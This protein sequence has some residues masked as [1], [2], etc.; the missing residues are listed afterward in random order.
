MAK[1]ITSEQVGRPLYYTINGQA[2]DGTLVE[3]RR[4][5]FRIV[6][7]ADGEQVPC[8]VS[9]KNTAHRIVML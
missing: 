2:Y 5:G 4:D 8:F 7:S 3:V 9:K 6:Y 1:R